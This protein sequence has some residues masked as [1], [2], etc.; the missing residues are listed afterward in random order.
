MY[1]LISHR[2][3]LRV[4]RYSLHFAEKLTYFPE[5]IANKWWSSGLNP[6]VSGSKFHAFSRT[7]ACLL[8]GCFLLTESRSQQE[9]LDSFS[10]KR[11]FAACGGRQVYGTVRPSSS[12]GL[13]ITYLGFS[14]FVSTHSCLFSI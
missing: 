5:D 11:E 8:P 10:K 4:L 2:N 7:P 3:S 14:R 9:P 1:T 6:S 12:D 13:S